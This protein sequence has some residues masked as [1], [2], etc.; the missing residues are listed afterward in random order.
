MSDH[1][2]DSHFLLDDLEGIE[3]L[4]DFDAAVHL[5]SKEAIAAYMTQMLKD[6]DITLLKKALDTVARAEGMAKVAETA[7]ISREGAYKALKP[8]SKPYL[9]TFIKLLGGVGLTIQIVPKEELADDNSCAL[10]A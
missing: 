2:K 3:G 9:E 4:E 7:G 10:A 8:S 5:T 1:D 6:G